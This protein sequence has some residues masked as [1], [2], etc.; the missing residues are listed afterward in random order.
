MFSR[1]QFTE[2]KRQ[3]RDHAKEKQKLVK[4]KDEFS[5]ENIHVKYAAA[6]ARIP[7]PHSPP[8]LC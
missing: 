3:E 1:W 5:I 6:P 8:E 7:A 2:L 4:D